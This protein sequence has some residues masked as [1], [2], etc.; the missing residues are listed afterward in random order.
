MQHEQTLGPGHVELQVA[1]LLQTR[2]HEAQ[3]LLHVDVGQRAADDRDWNKQSP[4]QSGEAF[5]RSR[6]ERD[7][8]LTL[9]MRHRF[10]HLL[11]QGF[12]VQPEGQHDG[13]RPVLKPQLLAYAGRRHVQVQV[14]RVEDHGPVEGVDQQALGGGGRP[15]AT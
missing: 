12:L 3:K 1:R 11:L 13:R 2:R 8:S 14:V 10:Q 5:I 4:D 6:G 7:G 15:A 9:V